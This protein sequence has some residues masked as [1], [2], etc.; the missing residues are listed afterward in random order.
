MPVDTADK[1]IRLAGVK[2][3]FNLEDYGVSADFIRAY[4]ISTELAFAAGIEALRDAGIPLVR[5]YKVSQSGKKIPTGWLLPEPM[6]DNTGIIFGSAFPGVDELIRNLNNNGADANGNFDRRFLFQVLAMGHSQ[7]AQFIGARGPNTAINAACA[8]T[9]KQS[10]SQKTG[11]K[12]VAA[13][14]LLWSARTMSQA[15]I[16]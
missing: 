15:T 4:D 8:S 10:L 13:S 14:A 11:S 3:A 7:F 5:K 16:C 1:V 2:S 12:S 6:R 9:H